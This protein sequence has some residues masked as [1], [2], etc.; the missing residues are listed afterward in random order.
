MYI[1]NIE[2]CI[3]YRVDMAQTDG[4]KAEEQRIKYKEVAK[5]NQCIELPSSFERNQNLNNNAIQ[6]LTVY[7]HVCLYLLQY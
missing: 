2:L 6:M 3:E 1:C 4:M 5:G 7:P